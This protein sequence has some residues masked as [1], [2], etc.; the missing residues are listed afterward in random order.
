MLLQLVSDLGIFG[1]VMLIVG[2]LLLLAEAASPGFFIAV[3]GTVLIVLGIIILLFPGLLENEWAPLVGVL[4]A[5]V[6]GALTIMLY[7]RIAPG[8]RPQATSMDTLVG[9]VGMVSRA[10]E[11]NNIKGKVRIDNQIWSAT[12]DKKIVTGM[13]IKVI[14][15]KGVHVRVKEEK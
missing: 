3:P 4:V 8:Q 12:A 11:P 14:G 7:R 1:W 9:K 10:I 6:A 2:V 15:S 5:V 13:K